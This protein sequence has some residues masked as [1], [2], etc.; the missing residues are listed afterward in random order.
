[1]PQATKLT[2][3]HNDVTGRTDYQFTAKLVSIGDK[4]RPNSNGKQYV[5]GTC[6]F[7]NQKGNIVQR[8]VQ[9]YN[10]NLTDK[11]GNIRMEVGNEYLTTASTDDEGNVYLRM[12]HLANASRA[13]ADDFDFSATEV[14]EKETNTI[15]SQMP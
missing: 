3:I 11:E 15:A 13:T 14:T 8:T 4:S 9:I 7:V 12:S 6:E 2:P 5:V 1:M 10:G